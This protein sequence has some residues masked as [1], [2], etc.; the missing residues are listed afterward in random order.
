MVGK[1]KRTKAFV[2]ATALSLGAS[3]S[4][5]GQHWNSA[6]AVGREAGRMVDDAITQ[7]DQAYDALGDPGDGPAEKLGAAVDQS[8]IVAVNFVR[9]AITADKTKSSHPT[10]DCAH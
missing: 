4:G 6:E 9:D 10:R 8:L 1:S 7:V 5:C 3:L 2:L